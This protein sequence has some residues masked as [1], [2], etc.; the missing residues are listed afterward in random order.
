[1]RGRTSVVLSLTLAL[2]LAALS[3]AQA[4]Y[5]YQPRGAPAPPVSPEPE[6]PAA[7]DPAPAEP[8]PLPVLVQQC[9]PAVVL[10]K[11]ERSGGAGQ[12][13]GVI[14]DPSGKVLTCHHVIEGAR[15][16]LVQMWNGG[17][18]PAEG[19]LGLNPSA[20]LAL[21][22]LSAQGLPHVKLGDS[23][24]LLPGEMCFVISAPGGVSKTVSD[25]IVSGLPLVRDLPR[26]AREQLL[27]QGMLPEQKLIQFTAPIYFGSSGGPLF[28]GRGEVVGIV[29]LRYAAD[30]V[31]FA[32]PA[33]LARPHLPSTT[34]LKFEESEMGPL[35]LGVADPELGELPEYVGLLEPESVE[36]QELV[37]RSGDPIVRLPESMFVVDDSVRVRF[38]DS[39]EALT[40]ARRMPKQ[41]EFR[42]V[43]GGFVYFSNKDRGRRVQ[44]DYEYRVQRVAVLQTVN[45]TDYEELD[46]FTRKELAEELRGRGFQVVPFLEVDA[47]VRAASINISAT[48][49]DDGEALEP[50]SIRRIAADANAALVVYSGVAVAKSALT[51]ARSQGTG[52]A[53]GIY[54]GH[55]GEDLFT[56]AQA[57][58]KMVLFG[59]RRA[60]REGC[61][62][63]AIDQILDEF[64]GK[65]E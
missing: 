54:D 52:V 13:S 33:D 40:K 30:N 28:N 44:I 45:M 41:G 39:N 50:D 27:E 32:I 17:Y 8:I 58:T 43:P 53:I 12:G 7:A 57:E 18:F 63:R 42:V 16:A 6:P 35:A 47:A 20:D 65:E 34:V 31:Y 46:D 23:E 15:S 24:A 4:Q 1:M 14:V 22:K 2:A 64:L 5:V 55:T 21:L 61:I 59:G 26:E 37:P 19:V 11:V 29:A 38:Y 49:Y 56:K 51:H 62:R 36:R 60:A 10:I 25:G 48:A 9:S 3:A